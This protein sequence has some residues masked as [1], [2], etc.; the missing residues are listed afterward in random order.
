MI[1][2][3]AN[4]EKIKA[5]TDGGIADIAKKAGELWKAMEDKS[6]SSY[7]NLKS[8]FY[9]DS[10]ERVNIPGVVLV[11]FDDFASLQQKN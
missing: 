6:V 7:L 3:N 1:W 8:I 9:I 10:V 5:Q 2:M 11:V 4:R